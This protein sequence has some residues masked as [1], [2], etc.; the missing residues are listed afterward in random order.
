L[1]ALAVMGNTRSELLPEVP[2]MAELKHPEVDFEV[3][4]VLAAPAGMD[5]ARQQV[6]VDAFVRAMGE[7]YIQARLKTMDVQAVIQTGNAVTETI[8]QLSEQNRKLIEASGM[9]V[10]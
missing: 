1:N 7:P 10:D 9:Q 2:T 6:I 5:P 8:Q 4:Y 3:K